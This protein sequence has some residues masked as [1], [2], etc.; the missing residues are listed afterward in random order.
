M[1]SEPT[2]P[3][4]RVSMYLSHRHVYMCKDSLMLIRMKVRWL[5]LKSR[6]VLYCLIDC[7]YWK[8]TAELCSTFICFESSLYGHCFRLVSIIEYIKLYSAPESSIIF[9]SPKHSFRTSSV[10]MYTAGSWTNAA[11]CPINSGLLTL[12]VKLYHCHIWELRHCLGHPRKTEPESP[13]GAS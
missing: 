12:T 6:C 3:V 1:C 13:S 8:L 2:F 11:S 9:V 10:Y 5:E 4:W 7:F